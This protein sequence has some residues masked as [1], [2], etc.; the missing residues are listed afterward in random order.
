MTFQMVVQ[1]L[2]PRLRFKVKNKMYAIITK[3]SL[4]KYYNLLMFQVSATVL[5][6]LGED[7]NITDFQVNTA[8]DGMTVTELSEYQNLLANTTDLI[9]K[10][11]SL[12]KLPP[13]S[14]FTG[15]VTLDFNGCTNIT[16]IPTSYPPSLQAIKASST[17]LS[18][19][20]SMYNQIKLLDVSNC[21]RIA[22]ISIPSL[23]TLIMS[24]SAITEITQLDNLIRIIALNTKVIHIPV[25]PN[26]VVVMWSGISNSVLTIDAAN[27][28]IV[29]IL[30]SGSETNISSPNGLITSLML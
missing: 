12:T 14:L 15:L 3:M 20:P 19:I 23:Q 27:T 30:T 5:E 4:I 11:K 8:E 29:Q 10:V 25:A 6:V 2:T 28:S 1:I 18:S 7:T 16:Q 17:K 26:L 13:G 24:H 21:K 22:S 9:F